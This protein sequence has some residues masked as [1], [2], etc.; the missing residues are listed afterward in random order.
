MD[1]GL[2]NVR[3]HA[4]GDIQSCKFEVTCFSSAYKR[5]NSVAY[6][7]NACLFK[8]SLRAFIKR[9]SKTTKFFLSV[10]NKVIRS[11]ELLLEKVYCL[12][13]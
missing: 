5:K 3:D 13:R 1:R 9:G 12:S 8:S 6:D 2:L 4:V 10:F 11:E 7:S